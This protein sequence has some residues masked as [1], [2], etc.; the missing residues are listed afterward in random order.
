MGVSSENLKLD[1]LSRLESQE[2]HILGCGRGQK[3]RENVPMP[4]RYLCKFRSNFDFRKMPFPNY[5]GW[6]LQNGKFNFL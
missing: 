2:R 1:F 6:I 5:I 3:D 4:A